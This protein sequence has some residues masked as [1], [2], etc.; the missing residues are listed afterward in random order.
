M[1]V[2][3]YFIRKSELHRMHANGGSSTSSTSRSAESLVKEVIHD[4]FSPGEH[5][6]DVVS[7][8]LASAAR[9]GTAAVK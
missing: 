8:L 6:I 3:P 5:I 7:P 4:V 1:S 2:P 9:A